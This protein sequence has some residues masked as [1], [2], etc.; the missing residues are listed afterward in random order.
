MHI[1]QPDDNSERPYD[2]VV[3]LIVD[4]VYDYEDISEAALARAKLALIDSLGVAI[5]SL[6][7]SKE[8]AALVKPILPG[9]VSVVGGFRLPGT[10]YS[11]DLLQGAFD[12]GAM[13]RY[14]D[15]NDA[16][17]GAEW[18]H[19]SDNLG[20]IIA[21]ADVLTRE[22][23]AQGKSDSVITIKQVLI[24]LIKAYEIQG[25]F[26]IKNAF[27]RV[28]LDHTILV[29][30]GSTAVVSWMMGLS[31]EQAR[32]A[33]SHAWVDGHPLRI[34][35]QAPNAGPRKGWAAG[36][37]C[38][39]A[40]HLAALARAGQPGI[41]TSLTAPRWGFYE[42]LNKG[43]HFQL[44]K[45]F[46]T[47]VIENSVFKVLTAEG[48]GLTA[49]EATMA[50][51]KELQARGLDPIQDIKSIRVR[52]QEPAMIII[53]KKGPLNNPADRDHCLRYMMAVVLLKNGVEVETEDY[54]D[55]SPWA[56]DARVEK[57]RSIISMEEDVQ[58]TRDYHNPDIRSVGSSM[59]FLLQDG[60]TIV[61]RQDFPLGHPARGDETIPLVRQKAVRNLALGF[62][63]DQV[64]G[65]MATLDQ[66]D[67]ESLPASTF[68]DLFQK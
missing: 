63:Q 25:V 12:M 60:T 46:G 44:P 6:T 38:M 8:C 17:A 64:D 28:G 52:T 27:N 65:I 62:S 57:L 41:R 45:G 2:E 33:V 50:A 66:A 43:Q 53:N 31:R 5:E 59:E 15:H 36:D 35:R 61:T 16:F 42:V 54:Q 49:V 21:T 47:W 40:V 48:H 7:K 68:I 10:T 67:F 56:T 18:G 20:A 26:Q 29:K 37:A 19:P 1:P 9:A 11:L 55:D 24:S 3:T 22:A 51:S 32:S 23:L 30:V 13:I 4:Y 39:R 34:F 14:L 58:F